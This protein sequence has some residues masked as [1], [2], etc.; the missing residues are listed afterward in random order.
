MGR[1]GAKNYGLALPLINNKRHEKND[2][3][4]LFGVDD[5]SCP[6]PGPTISGAGLS[7]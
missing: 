3:I 7:K 5:L 6:V 4:R 2:H 1:F